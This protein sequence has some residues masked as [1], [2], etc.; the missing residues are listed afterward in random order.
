MLCALKT[1]VGNAE[2]DRGVFGVTL[3]GH[4]NRNYVK[5]VPQ[6]WSL[7]NN[8]FSSFVNV[9]L[10]SRHSRFGGTY[11]VQNMKSISENEI[12]CLKPLNKISNLD[13]SGSK[14]S[15]LVKPKHRRPVEGGI[16]ERRSAFAIR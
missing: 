9:I 5:K 15:K 10:H 2:S 16:L 11:V 3:Y 13:F 4:S 12:I 8:L 1:L 7:D 6:V 14:K